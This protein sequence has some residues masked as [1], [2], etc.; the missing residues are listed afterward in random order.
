MTIKQFVALFALVLT[1]VGAHASIV[2]T[3]TRG[4]IRSSAIDHLGL[5]GAAGADLGGMTFATTIRYDRAPLGNTIVD[6]NVDMINFIE[7]RPLPLE[8]EIAINGHTYAQ[9][10]TV[11]NTLFHYV[12]DGA[13]ARRDQAEFSVSAGNASSWFS[14]SMFVISPD[15]AFMPGLPRLESVVSYAVQPGD[16]NVG[17]FHFSTPTGTEPFRHM[18]FSTTITYFGLNVTDAAVPEPSTLWLLA[19]GLVIGGAAMARRNGP[20]AGRSRTAG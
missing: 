20:A 11:V 8:V 3:S 6:P 10:F 1:Q 16:T 4:V 15:G 2:T 17:Q 13:G 9:R 19:L 14:W 18:G 5:F 12:R 7:Q